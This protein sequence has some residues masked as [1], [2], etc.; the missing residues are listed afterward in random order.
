MWIYK[1]VLLTS[2]S[3]HWFIKEQPDFNKYKSHVTMEFQSDEE[4]EEEEDNEELAA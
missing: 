3:C 1:L 4:P 2:L